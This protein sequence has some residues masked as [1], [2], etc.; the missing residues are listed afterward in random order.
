MAAGRVLRGDAGLVN[1]TPPPTWF[2]LVQAATGDPML[3][4]R[5]PLRWRRFGMVGDADAERLVE[6][7]EDVGSGLAPAPAT[8]N[9]AVETV[10]PRS[11]A[12]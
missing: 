8:A 2:I 12:A 10:D 11:V 1:P 4:P 5:P 6:V 7:V 9:F 3:W